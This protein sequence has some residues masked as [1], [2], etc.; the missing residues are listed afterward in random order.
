MWKALCALTLLVPAAAVG[1]P[2]SSRGVNAHL[3][4]P[5]QLDAIR[6]VGFGWVRF[7]FNWNE[8]EPAKG[9]FNW[10][11]WDAAVDHAVSQGLSVFATLAY[12]PKW[13]AVDPG[14]TVCHIVPFA[15]VSD[16]TAF[17]TAVVSRY[18]GKVS[19][20]GMWNEPNLKSFY[21]GT[22]EQYVSDILV[23]GAAAVKAADPGAKVLGPELAGLTK[24]SH[25][26]GDEGQCLL[27]QCIFNGWEVDLAK[28]LSAA[29]G[30]IDVITHHFY[31]E[32]PAGIYQA[33]LDGEEGLGWKTHS[34][35]REIVDAHAPG[36]PVWLT[37][38]GWKTKPYGQ[39]AG[40]GGDSEEDQAAY[41]VETYERLTQVRMGTY[42]G[43]SNDPWPALEKLFVYD[44]HDGVS[45][46]ELWTF[47]LV[48][49]DGSPKPVIAALTASFAAHQE[50]CGGN[51]PE[52]PPK[53]VVPK[54]SEA[55]LVEGKPDGDI[56]EWTDAMLPLLL[57][58]PGDWVAL[59]GGAPV[60]AMD[61]GARV[62]LGW[63]PGR[64]RLGVE[65]TDDEHAPVKDPSWAGDSLQ[66][67]LDPGYDKTKGAYDAGDWEVTVAHGATPVVACY[68]SPPVGCAVAVGTR[69][70]GASSFY[71]VDIPHDT[72]GQKV[73][74]LSVLVNESDGAGREGWLEWTPGIGL[75]KDPSAF[76]TVTLVGEPG[77]DAGAQDAGGSAGDASAPSGDAGGGDAG[78]GG[79]GGGGSGGVGDTGGSAEPGGVISDAVG[80]GF[81][82][83]GEDA[84]SPAPE[85]PADD[86][87]GA[88]GG[89]S[90]LL[91][92]LAVRR[93]R[94]SR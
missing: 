19:H 77:P 87:C 17:V 42:A 53:G 11:P 43:S 28:V 14:C 80:G 58:P 44:W 33:I 10:G 26:S 31:K 78:G 68:A 82:A 49:D 7:D 89:T 71:E 70:V 18:K 38:W 4:S 29:G 2:C 65:V 94:T 48:R 84:A 32:D 40:S 36:K 81:N 5:D 20:W 63:A 75:A 46:G 25:W 12:T 52:G 83:Q 86:G 56:G 24:S 69:R 15:K 47:G 9:Q 23:P 62:Y 30:S 67:A 51:F 91:L 3:Q 92:L 16:W 21:L 50:G 93:R 59:S 66:V 61:L 76:A 64:L 74:G 34:A 88:A 72:A 8:M 60:S 41:V 27:G 73:V 90:G 35:L 45:E 1:D 54:S 22:A 79:A 85:R 57:T 13:A 55:I 37:E 39:F 6:A